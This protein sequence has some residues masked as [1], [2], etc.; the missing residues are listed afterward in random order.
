MF[1]YDKVLTHASAD[2]NLDLAACFT[3]KHISIKVVSRLDFC[4][5]WTR[6]NMLYREFQT[7][8]CLFAS[9]I[10]ITFCVGRRQKTQG[11]S[12][13][14]ITYRKRIGDR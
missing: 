9:G 7:N 1:Q 2:L 5:F 12:A 10:P 3:A 6:K 4:L 14:H 8:T 11:I 13:A